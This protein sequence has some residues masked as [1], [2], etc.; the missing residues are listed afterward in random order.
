MYQTDSG[1]SLAI[2]QKRL[3]LKCVMVTELFRAVNRT[4]GKFPA[5]QR[6]NKSGASILYGS[7]LGP[8]S[9]ISYP[10]LGLA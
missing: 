1:W 3:R 8:F 5:K 6:S 7:I 4:T 9:L 2:L 10:K